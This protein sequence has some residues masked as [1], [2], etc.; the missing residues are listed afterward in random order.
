MCN[1]FPFYMPRTTEPD[2]V[3]IHLVSPMKKHM[4]EK[5]HLQDSKLQ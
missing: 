2:T 1:Q 5:K 4:E 3:E